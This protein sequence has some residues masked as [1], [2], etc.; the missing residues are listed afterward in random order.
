MAFISSNQTRIIYGAN[1]LAAILRTVSPSTSI[2]MLETTSLAD[3]AKTFLPGLKDASLSVDGLF[4]NTTA[5]GSFQVN[6]L[7]NISATSSVPTSV[8]SSGFALGNSVFLMNAKTI[9]YE[10]S[11]AVADLVSFSMSLGS[12]TAPGLGVSLG[13]LA[14][15]TAT[16]NGTSVDNAAG[17]TNGG[18]A[19]LHIT[20]VSGTTPTMTVIIQH[21]TN[22]S[23]FTTLASF[24]AATAV[25]SESISFTGTVNRYVRAQY[26]VG[27]TSPSFTCQVSLA[28]N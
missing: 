9:T 2:D 18:I 16:A 22:N 26:T 11:S 14:S 10:V 6:V 1:P 7:S 24:T 12:A 20:E 15:I 19:N 27:G 21:S 4:D 8:A 25:T 3:T 17:T 13:D 23:T 5:A 28:R